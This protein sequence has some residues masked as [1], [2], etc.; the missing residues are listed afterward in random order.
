MSSSCVDAVASLYDAVSP[1]RFFLPGWEEQPAVQAANQTNLPGGS[2]TSA[3]I[4]VIQGTA[5]EVVPFGTTTTFVDQR[6]CRSQ[7]DTVDYVTEDG[8]GHAQALDQS[9]AV[10]N[11]WVQA[12]FSGGSTVDSCT[13]P[14][15]GVG[16]LG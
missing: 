10:I 2:P 15:L 12:R 6:L 8:V 1:T 16:H 3:P 14:G 4:L 13:R 5:D 7:Y 11:H 9:D